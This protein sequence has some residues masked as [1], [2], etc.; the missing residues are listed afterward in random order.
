MRLKRIYYVKLV[1][2]VYTRGKACK[3]ASLIK[4]VDWSLQADRGPD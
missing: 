2:R 3:S 4:Y 1:V